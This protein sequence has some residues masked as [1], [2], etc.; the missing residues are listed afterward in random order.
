MLNF[1]FFWEFTPRNLNIEILLRWAKLSS[2]VGAK[3]RLGRLGTPWCSVRNWPL[4]HK[5]CYMT[6][7]M[8]D[9]FGIHAVQS[10]LFY[11]LGAHER[12]C[13]QILWSNKTLFFRNE[14][15]WMQIR[16]DPTF[17]L[18]AGRLNAT[19]KVSS[20]KAKKL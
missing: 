15:C 14:R 7:W 17:R 16:R 9:I 2:L 5:D 1:V 20:Y 8:L 19:S 6:T 18:E 12:T 3:A 13:F 11:S 4:P 10:A